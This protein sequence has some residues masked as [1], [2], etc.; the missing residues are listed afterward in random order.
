[1]ARP[2]IADERLS[3]TADNSIKLRLKNQWRDGTESILFS[4]SEFI[5]KLIALVPIPRFHLTRYYGVFANRSQF[6]SK[7]PDMPEPPVNPHLGVINEDN[8][9]NASDMD[10][11]KSGKSDKRSRGKHYVTWAALLRRTFGVDVL[12]CPKCKAHMSLVEVVFDS[13][14]IAA[15]LTAIGVSPRA[16]PIAAV[17]G[18]GVFGYVD[19]EPIVEWDD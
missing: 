13:R 10:G 5:E 4:P 3:L 15:T 2:A 7:L 6:R 14:A 9:Q 19:A 12:Q 18:T 1:M 16:P 17:C 11:N 8:K